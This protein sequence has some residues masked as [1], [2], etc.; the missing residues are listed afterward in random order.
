MMYIQRAM[1]F[2]SR[3]EI[4]AKQTSVHL[5]L[6]ASDTAV[7]RHLALQARELAGGEVGHAAV[8]RVIHEVGYFS[9]SASVHTFIKQKSTH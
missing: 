5:Q 4:N 7:G 3:R 8:V 1:C 6:R 9:S 2:Y